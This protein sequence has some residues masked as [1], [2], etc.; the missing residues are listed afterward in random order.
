MHDC[1]VKL[2]KNHDEESLECLCRLLTT[3]GKDLDFEKA[4]V[5]QGWRERPGWKSGRGVFL[6][7]DLLLLPEFLYGTRK[8]FA[9]LWMFWHD[10]ASLWPFLVESVSFSTV[11]SSFLVSNITSEHTGCAQHFPCVSSSK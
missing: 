11:F 1:V 2:L 8:L 3:I 6:F 4:K 9:L 7:E 10:L 5:G